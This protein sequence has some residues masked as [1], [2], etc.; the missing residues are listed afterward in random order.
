M[1]SGPVNTLFPKST[2]FSAGRSSHS[3][4]LLGG[5]SLQQPGQHLARG[6]QSGTWFSYHNY[7]HGVCQSK[8]HHMENFRFPLLGI[9]W[10]YRHGPL[11]GRSVCTSFIFI[12]VLICVFKMCM[13]SFI[14]A[15]ESFCFSLTIFF[16]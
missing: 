8:F 4:K 9:G 1:L 5:L 15:V 11:A 13:R 10:P 12:S 6:E 2:S 7:R 14:S 3:Q 16:F